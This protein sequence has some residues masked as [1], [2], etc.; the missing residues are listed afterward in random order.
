MQRSIS[1]E[2]ASEWLLYAGVALGEQERYW[3]GSLMDLGQDLAA[4]VRRGGPQEL[5]HLARAMGRRGGPLRRRFC[6]F[7]RRLARAV[8]EEK[9]GPL[10]GEES[11][12]LMALFMRQAEE[13]TAEE[14]AERDALSRRAAEHPHKKR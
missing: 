11:K 6:L 8:S 13:L 14:R 7:A 3:F 4:A 1:R 10:S 12:R 5:T 9:G 2:E